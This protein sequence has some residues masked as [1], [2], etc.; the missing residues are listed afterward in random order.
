MPVSQ[1]TAMRFPLGERL[2]N[3]FIEVDSYVYG[4]TFRR[5]ERNLGKKLSLDSA[6]KG[7]FRNI[8]FLLSHTMLKMS[9]RHCLT[10]QFLLDA[11]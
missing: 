9:V 3:I 8:F 4:P 10:V 7:A 6:V 11:I 5:E 1:S 2:Y